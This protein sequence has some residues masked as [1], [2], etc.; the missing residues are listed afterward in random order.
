MPT[1]PLVFVGRRRSR[2]LGS[3]ASQT[4]PSLT[5][6]PSF[7]IFHRVFS[8]DKQLECGD[9]HL[10]QDL[11]LFWS[12]TATS[13]S[14]N[15]NQTNP[16]T[17]ISAN[18]TRT[19]QAPKLPPSRNNATST[20]LVPFPCVLELPSSRIGGFAPPSLPLHTFVFAQPISAAR[21]TV[22][23]P[24]CNSNKSRGE[25]GGD[26]A[27]SD[28]T[29]RITTLQNADQ[30]LDVEEQRRPRLALAFHS[31]VIKSGLTTRDYR[32]NSPQIEFTGRQRHH[33]DQATNSVIRSPSLLAAGVVKAAP[34]KGLDKYDKMERDSCS[35]EL[36]ASSCS[37][38][39]G[40]KREAHGN[41]GDEVSSAV[42]VP[43]RFG[44]SLGEPFHSQRVASARFLPPDEAAKK[45]EDSS[46]DLRLVTGKVY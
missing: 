6:S 41:C 18:T 26:E 9:R 43:F 32:R 4:C 39:G 40:G 23:T 33:R 14:P 3:I 2:Q 27:N 45:G 10:A 37:L 7:P 24:S 42:L 35:I 13:A 38:K 11:R 36:S 31:T 25:A 12:P 46:P 19:K 21:S 30:K 22:A 44:Y 1:Q 17:I 34:Q 29:A 5:P 20:P 15:Q 28:C 8:S 16:A